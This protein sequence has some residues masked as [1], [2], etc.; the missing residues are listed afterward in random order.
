MVRGFSIARVPHA[1]AAG[2]VPV[3][4]SAA[5]VVTI[6]QDDI[7]ETSKRIISFE[8]ESYSGQFHA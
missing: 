3:P 6:P 2:A 1:F 8:G 5:C 7:G 4:A